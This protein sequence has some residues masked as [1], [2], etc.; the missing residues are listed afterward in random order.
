MTNGELKMAHHETLTD[1]YTD[2][3]KDLWSANDQM[4]KVVKN[5]SNKAHD[6]ALKQ[7]LEQSIKG[8]QKHAKTLQSLISEAGAEVEPEH[9]KG[10][11]GLV[12][13]ANKHIGSE[14]PDSSDLLDIVI[15]SQYQRMSH[16]GLAGFGAAAAYAKA[17]G[18]KD[19]QEKLTK[20][21]SDIYAG[22][23]F[24]SKRAETVEK[25]AARAAKAA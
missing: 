14:A 3:M 19:H 22:D 16:Y 15:I 4:T 21:V 12:K 25:V 8:I 17:L 10:M 5:M 18:R 20:I 11:E 6:P 1:V 9:C 23:E 13:E 7:A 2:E 24:A